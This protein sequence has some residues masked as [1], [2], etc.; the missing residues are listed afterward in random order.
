MT[1]GLAIIVCMIVFVM[2]AL[3]LAS[4]GRT[5]EENVA[6][7]ALAN[8][9]EILSLTECDVSETTFNRFFTAKDAL[10]FRITVK[11]SNGEIRNGHLWTRGSF[12]NAV[13]R[14]QPK[15]AWENKPEIKS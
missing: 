13:Y 6:K 10:F 11:T 2:I 5:H 1:F 12:F 8:S 14:M 15:V 7:W 3:A 9:F 4:F